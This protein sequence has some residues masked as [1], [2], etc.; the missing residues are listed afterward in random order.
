MAAFT[1]LGVVAAVAVAAAPAVA[2]AAQD[3]SRAAATSQLRVGADKRS[4]VKADGSPFF[5]MGDTA[6]SLFVSL[7]RREAIEYLDNRAKLGFTVIQA[8]AVEPPS[9][10]LGPNAYG[11]MPYTG[12]I[13]KPLVTR[14]N[15]PSD[16][17][18]YDYWDHI[19][20]VVREAAKRGLYIAMLP[21][22][23]RAAASESLT[24]RNAEAYGR[25]LGQRFA[26]R[27]PN[28]IWLAGGDTQ[29]FH[30][31]IW[32]ELAAGLGPRNK[33]LVGYHPGG[34]LNSASALADEPWMDFNTHQS[35]HD[36]IDDNTS[37]WENLAL[38]FKA[39]PRR[40]FLDAEPSYEQHP[41]DF[42]AANGYIGADEVRA[43]AYVS[44][45]SGAAG[46]TY[47]HHNVWMMY[48]AHRG[49][50]GADPKDIHW[51]AA[52][53]APGARQMSHLARLMAAHPA[54]RLPAPELVATS[55]EAGDRPDVLAAR[56]A[57][58]S[59]VLV[60]TRK[61]RGFRLDTAPAARAIRA[62]WL[63]PRTGKK[64]AV[65]NVKAAKSVAFTPPTR[66][67]DWVL[68]VDRARAT[69]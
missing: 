22:W 5:W 19:E 43:A 57:N 11:D 31:E 68:V 32:R 41:V 30:P 63:D 13:D 28:I 10:G 15:S 47:G 50:N 4:F 18:Q 24:E 61:G 51:R 59:Y 34:G 42:E 39:T 23:G 33:V 37:L 65:P 20:F 17:A 60:Y 62:Y 29:E 53:D 7:D 66:D 64:A 46:H 69:N 45:L 44:V 35:G 55:G 27:H 21:A 58:N 38:S 16:N 8:V 14:G 40:P 54:P 56:A 1:V 36:R 3:V 26:S 9:A 67:T 2:P 49:G 25:F 52:L 6:W 48:G 12:S